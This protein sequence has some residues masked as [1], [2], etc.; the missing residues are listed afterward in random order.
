[1]RS[2]YSLGLES[3]NQISHFICQD[4]EGRRHVGAC[5]LQHPCINRSIHEWL[6]ER[7]R[8]PRS[9]RHRKVKTAFVRLT[10]TVRPPVPL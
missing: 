8:P 3:M 1:M 6:Y 10:V 4:T 7:D 9:S 2:A 5:R